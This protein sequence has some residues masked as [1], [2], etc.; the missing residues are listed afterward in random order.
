MEEIQP[1]IETVSDQE[2][3]A[4]TGDQAPQSETM[5]QTSQ[6]GTGE[7]AP[8]SGLSRQPFNWTLLKEELTYKKLWKSRTWSDIFQHFFKA[9]LIGLIPTIFDV[10]TDCISS[11]HYYTG[12]IYQKTVSTI[13]DPAVNSSECTNTGHYVQVGFT[14]I[15]VSQLICM[16]L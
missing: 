12:D 13:T 14:Y 1:V 7:Q 6:S 10:C 8:Q 4:E 9:L 11:E 15:T 2:P 3:Q 16:V 5:D